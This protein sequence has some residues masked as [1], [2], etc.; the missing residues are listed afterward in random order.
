MFKAFCSLSLSALTLALMLS[1]RPQQDQSPQGTSER[2][3][4]DALRSQ[5][6]GLYQGYLTNEIHSARNSLTQAV[7]LIEASST[8]KAAEE[9]LWLGYARLYCVDSV[10]GDSERARLNYE[11]ARYWLLVNLESA[12]AS[13]GK[14]VEEL[15]AFTPE[16]CKEA[17]LEWD[18]AFTKGQGPRFLV[19]SLSPTNRAFGK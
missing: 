5:L 16:A 18:R 15:T 9:I 19:E 6:D 8:R 13:P 7:H 4:L 10:L 11:K 17:A 14:V 3:R 1:C 2:A 12:G